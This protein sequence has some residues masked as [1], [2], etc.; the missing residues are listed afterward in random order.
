MSRQEIIDTHVFVT[1]GACGPCRFRDGTRPSTA[2]PCATRASTGS[3][4]CSSSSRAASTSQAWADGF[5]MN[6]DFFLAFL[7]AL[8]MGDVLNDVGYQMR[9]FEIEEGATDR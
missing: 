3:G 6:V 8:N 4:S 1:A 9:P 2:W 7:N 5:E